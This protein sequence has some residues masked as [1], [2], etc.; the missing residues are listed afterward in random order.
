MTRTMATHPP[1]PTDRLGLALLTAAVVHGLV[2]L[3][4]SF[5]A[6][7]WSREAQARGLDII[8]VHS[9]SDAPDKADYLA[10]ENQRGGGNI[11]E[12]IRPSS[13]FPNARPIQDRGNAPETR[14]AAAP[15]PEPDRP[16]GMVVTQGDSRWQAREETR[17]PRPDLQQPSAEELMARSLEAA[18]LSA[19]IRQR[20][21]AYAQM[22]RQEWVT[23]NTRKYDT[24]AYEEA[25][26]EKI[27]R[28]GNMNYPEEA[29]RKRLAGAL[30]LDVAIRPD[31][32]LAS[33][34]VQRSSGHRA[35]DEGA[36]R[37]VRLAA[38]FAPFSESMRKRMDL[39]H[40][41]RTW[42]FEDDS[43]TSR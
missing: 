35:L 33:A 41:V 14:D 18:R 15:R 25:W 38:P 19:E 27:E 32:S 10:Q 24:A 37:I 12:R 42:Q 40:I 36:L 39:L 16:R 29:R 9:K 6:E 21:E 7:K 3:G 4:V 5:D 8:L 30:I 43:L 17:Q 20:Q 11:Q 31:G 13:P 23:A 1:S 26:R 2:I 22:P 28:V 34:K